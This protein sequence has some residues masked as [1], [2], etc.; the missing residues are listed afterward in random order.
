MLLIAVIN[1]IN[2]TVAKSLKR[3]KE[4]G[5]RKVLGSNRKQLIKQFLAESFLLCFIAFMLGLFLTTLVLPLFNML[6]NKELAFSYLFDWKLVTGLI[7]ILVLTSMSAGFYPA[8]ILSGF[9]PVKTLYKRF[10]ITGKNYLQKTLIVVQFSLA[11]FLIVFTIV[12]YM[13]FNHLSRANLGYNDNNLVVVNKNVNDVDDAVFENKL[14]KNRNIIGI[15][16]A[17]TDL[18]ITAKDEANNLIQAA[19]ESV[20]ENY[21]PLLKIRLVTGRNFSNS[22]PSDSNH[23]ILVNE[24]F[25]KEA[26]WKSPLGKTLNL[27]TNRGDK[28]YRVIGVVKDYHYA[29]LNQ[30]IGPQLFTM[31]KSNLHGTFFIKIR[32]GTEKESLK[33][34][35]KSFS[36]IFP[37]IPYSYTFKS[38]DN[39]QQ[40]A[41][42]S[43][44]KE[45]VLFAAILTILISCV[46]LFGLSILSAQKRTKEIGIRKVLGASVREIITTL[47]KDFLILVCIALFISMPF[48]WIASTKWLQKYPYHVRLGWE[49]FA[50]AA[51]LVV[52]IALITVSFQ[53]IKAAIANPVKSL[54]SE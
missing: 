34:I 3:A 45:I 47:S 33:F 26:R 30:S 49:L 22:F 2:I 28:I 51:I 29:S 32:P 40:Y 10:N 36:R 7:L 27:S 24:E 38:D 12:L 14:L 37:L 46:G 48:A 54:R 42:L 52:L 50:G 8:I 9:D 43:K 39:R 21:F 23:S 16:S 20:D 1:F 41:D 25:V 15:S 5:I 13:Q 31:K 19:Y 35:Q 4:I 6:A 18:S 44:W 53:S 17:N 11:S